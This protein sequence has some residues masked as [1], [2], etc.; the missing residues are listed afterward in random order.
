MAK[1]KKEMLAARIEYEIFFKEFSDITRNLTK[2]LTLVQ[3]L[4]KRFFSIRVASKELCKN[5]DLTQEAFTSLYVIKKMC[6]ELVEED[7]KFSALIEDLS[8]TKLLK[9]NLSL[10][11][12]LSLD[13][14]TAKD[15][16][17]IKDL[18]SIEELDCN[19]YIVY[20]VADI[21]PRQQYRF[22]R[23]LN[24]TIKMGCNMVKT[25]I[26]EME[27]ITTKVRGRDVF[28]AV[29]PNYDKYLNMLRNAPGSFNNYRKISS[30]CSSSLEIAYCVDYFGGVHKANMYFLAEVTNISKKSK[31]QVNFL[32]TSVPDKLNVVTRYLEQEDRLVYYAVPKIDYT[33]RA[34]NIRKNIVD[35]CNDK[36]CRLAF[37]LSNVKTANLLDISGKYVGPLPRSAIY[38]KKSDEE[39]LSIAETTSKIKVSMDNLYVIAS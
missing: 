21:S 25:K 33:I 24:S 37:A 26:G 7:I 3:D 20:A 2:E 8:S 30:F 1:S 34:T 11:R 6:K 10:I 17:L 31:E 36:A 18:S 13:N 9:D 12:E 39:L 38:T 5:L 35:Y 28:Y 23:F 16:S 22:M 27:Y 29:A 14:D 32:M 19:Q 15:L 4:N